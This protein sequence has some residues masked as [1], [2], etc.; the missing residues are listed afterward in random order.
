M[1]VL[2][3]ASRPLGRC[4]MQLIMMCPELALFPCLTTAPIP[5]C[6]FPTLFLTGC[7]HH[8]HPALCCTDHLSHPWLDSEG[9][10]QRHCLPFH[11]QCEFSAIYQLTTPGLQI[12]RKKSMLDSLASRPAH[13]YMV[14]A[15]C[16][17]PR[18]VSW[19][20]RTWQGV[21]LRVGL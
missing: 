21:S 12:P 19:L 18:L 17:M 6:V 11:T 14:T 1:C 2:S 3:V 5:H 15:N 20:I 8:L 9:C 10:H 4:S 13:F 7:V 16:L